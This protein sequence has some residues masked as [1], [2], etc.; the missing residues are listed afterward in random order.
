M[1]KTIV[2]CLIAFSFITACN[3]ATDAQNQE[4]ERIAADPNNPAN[5]VNKLPDASDEAAN[6]EMQR[7]Q[8][9][10]SQT[11]DNITSPYR[12]ITTS[13][14]F[15]IFGALVKAS[16][17]SKHIHGGHVTLLAPKNEAFESF[18]GYTKLLDP[19]NIDKL[20]TFVS[21][22]VLDKSYTY[23]T[24]KTETMVVNHAG[25]QLHVNTQGG[26]TIE[27]SS[28]G[29]EEIYTNDGLILTMNELFYIPEG[30]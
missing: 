27:K 24:L 18:P 15:S 20:D 2:L 13:E 21:S 19:S 16:N 7:K 11:V 17:I 9:E 28:V 12:Y 22:Y 25:K 1:K 5:L 26:V 8:Q 23:K 4:A 30:I 29:S 3:N 10:V 14:K 6:A